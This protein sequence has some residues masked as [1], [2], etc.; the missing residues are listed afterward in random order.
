LIFY[1]AVG[2]G[3]TKLTWQAVNLVAIAR[4]FLNADTSAS[5]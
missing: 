1:A 3:Q 4:T 5:A 2:T